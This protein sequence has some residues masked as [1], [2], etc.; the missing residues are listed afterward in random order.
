[1]RN[2]N[3]SQNL[4]KK[5]ILRNIMNK[6]LFLSK[7]TTS[8]NLFIY[9]SVQNIQTGLIVNKTIWQKYHISLIA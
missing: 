3:K 7:L 1:M 8:F 4:R 2:M 5:K 9:M 6:I